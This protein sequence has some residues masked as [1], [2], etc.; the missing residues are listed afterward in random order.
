MAQCHLIASLQVNTTS[1]SSNDSPTRRTAT[2][3]VAATGR[4]NCADQQDAVDAVGVDVAWC[5]KDLAACCRA[6]W[7]CSKRQLQ[8]ACMQKT[9]CRQHEQS[10][11]RYI[12][13]CPTA[14]FDMLS[15]SLWDSSSQ[16]L[17]LLACWLCCC[18]RCCR[19]CCCQTA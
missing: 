14:T 6:S 10:S 17:L 12:K 13:L 19:R 4:H 18:H 7:A 9:A 8:M 2:S 1:H 16:L 15:R 11:S 5:Q 3:A